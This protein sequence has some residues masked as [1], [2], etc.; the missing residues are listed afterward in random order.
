MLNAIF[1]IKPQYVKRIFSGEKK[2][3]FRTVVCKKT[4]KKIIIYETSPASKIVGEVSVVDIIKDTPAKL[5]EKTKNYSGIE[6][7]DFMS[8]FRNRKYAYAYVLDNPVIYN[9]QINL[10]ELNI[11]YA[12]QS[13]AYISDDVIPKSIVVNII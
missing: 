13:F 12:P 5:W 10:S 9:K 3:E 1:S 8:Y 4:I 2:F 6:Y 11:K 7:K